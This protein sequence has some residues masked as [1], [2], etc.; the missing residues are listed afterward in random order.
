MFR[1]SARIGILDDPVGGFHPFARLPRDQTLA[2]QGHGASG[3][4]GQAAVSQIMEQILP[5]LQQRKIRLKAPGELANER[6]DFQTP[7]SRKAVEA[8]PGIEPG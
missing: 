2:P 1:F 6:R 7:V 4:V 3:G 5:R 8:S